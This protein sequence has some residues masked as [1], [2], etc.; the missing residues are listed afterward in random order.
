MGA[1]II[2]TT[3]D[4]WSCVPELSE[5]LECIDYTK[6]SEYEIRNCVRNS[7]LPHLV[8]NL[9]DNLQDAINILDGINVNKEFETVDDEDE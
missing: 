4:G 3:H 5:V 2:K 6:D 1:R 8:E 7:S 9:R